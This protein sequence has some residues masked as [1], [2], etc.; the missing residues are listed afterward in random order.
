MSGNSLQMLW[1]DSQELAVTQK[2][3]NIPS[4]LGVFA[5]LENE[6]YLNLPV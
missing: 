6:V 1:D 2:P 4:L 5:N 3:L